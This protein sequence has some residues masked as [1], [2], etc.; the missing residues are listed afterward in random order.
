LTQGLHGRAVTKSFPKAL[1]ILLSQAA[2]LKKRQI[3]ELY[4]LETVI[5]DLG[6]EKGFFKKKSKKP[7]LDGP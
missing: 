5:L 2:H 1:S 6:Q 7:D 3:T 4:G